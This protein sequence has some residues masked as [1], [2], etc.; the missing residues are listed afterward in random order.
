[1]KH[2][3]ILLTALLFTTLCLIFSACSSGGGEGEGTPVDTT[4]LRIENI[5]DLPVGRSAPIEVI[6]FLPEYEE[7]LTYT[8][9]G[10][11]ISI[12]D[13]K[14][15]ARVA[16]KTVTVTAGGERFHATFTVTT[17]ESKGTL[18]IDP[19]YAWLGYP[20]VDFYPD[21][22]KPE[23]AEVL[24]YAYDESGIAIDAERGLIKPLKEG[25]YTVTASSES[26]ETTFTV[27][28]E[29]V[30]R[31]AKGANGRPRFSASEFAG[32]AS[33]RERQWQSK[34]NDGRTVLFI[35]DSFFD[36]Q[37]WSN[38]YSR[39]YPGMDA[40]CLG[41]SA[42]TTYDWED[43]TRGW[44]A[45]TKPDS[46]V[47]HIG[48]NNVYDDGDNV[49]ATVKA[50]RRLFTLMH[51]TLPDSKIYWHSISQRTYDDQKIGYVRQ[52]NSQ[53]KRWCHERDYMVYVDTSGQLTGDMLRDG[54]HPKEENYRIF[55]DTLAESGLTVKR[56]R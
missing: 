56:G 50:L 28:V 6:F 5:V 1:M 21:F 29:K 43:W 36:T 54:V 23:Q 34:G 45:R 46:I 26:F 4:P 11:D 41:I 40:L 42:T 24:K 33:D 10:K 32:Q 16:G 31:T 8:F 2:T 25:S 22:S 38:F 12:Q 17:V 52:I 15:T 37:F 53:L 35:G 14:V 55:V 3:A 27:K 44:L 9:E 51:D 39:S 13:G 30:D 19:V 18:N 7:A 20:D 48:T 47:M 49:L